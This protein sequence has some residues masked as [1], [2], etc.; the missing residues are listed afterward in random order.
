MH[1]GV[2]PALHHTLAK[3]ED[4]RRVCWLILSIWRTVGRS[5]A[6][7]MIENGHWWL[8]S[9]SLAV[10]MHSGVGPGRW[11]RR[12]D[13]VTNEIFSI[14]MRP[15]DDNGGAREEKVILIWMTVADRFFFFRRSVDQFLH[16]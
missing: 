4:M 5:F 11:W 15:H 13:A 16:V 8:Q 6:L 12:G 7:G 1:I 14:F 10:T 9:I 2:S 3:R